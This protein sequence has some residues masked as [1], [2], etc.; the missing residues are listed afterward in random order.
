[1]AVA[2]NRKLSPNSKY[3]ILIWLFS[4]APLGLGRTF[5]F[6]FCLEF[7]LQICHI[8]I[9]DDTDDGRE[10]TEDDDLDD[11]DDTLGQW[12]ETRGGHRCPD[13]EQRA[14]YTQVW[15]ALQVNKEFKNF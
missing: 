10:K 12:P 15:R 4:G 3:P 13:D 6:S 8:I 1:M 7:I 9:H 2:L 11:D 5:T 14:I